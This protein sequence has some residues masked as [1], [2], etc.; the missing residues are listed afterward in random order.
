MEDGLDIKSS[1]VTLPWSDVVGESLISMT[2]R[3]WPKERSKKQ[4]MLV[5]RER[6]PV[7]KT[8]MI[9]KLWF[10]FAGNYV[11]P[12]GASTGRLFQMERLTR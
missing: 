8:S 1:V 10:R 9:S 2:I 7:T 5:G 12:S 4:E 11:W 6:R 3:S